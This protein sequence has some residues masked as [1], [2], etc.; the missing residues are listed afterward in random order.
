MTVI[1]FVVPVLALFAVL[2][3]LGWMGSKAIEAFL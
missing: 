2:M 1:D 3:F